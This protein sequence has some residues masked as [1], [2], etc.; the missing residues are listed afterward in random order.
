[1]LQQKQPQSSA[2]VVNNNEKKGL[3]GNENYSITE[4]IM[5]FIALQAFLFIIVYN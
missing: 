1:M 5:Y 2:S 4:S 3:Q